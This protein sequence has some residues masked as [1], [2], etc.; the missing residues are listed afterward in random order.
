MEGQPGYLCKHENFGLVRDSNPRT[1]ASQALSP[2]RK[3]ELTAI[4]KGHIKCMKIY[5]S[6][7]SKAT[8]E[9]RAL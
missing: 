7:R 1:P 6:E 2:G 8:D 4:P 9:N 3:Y 5:K